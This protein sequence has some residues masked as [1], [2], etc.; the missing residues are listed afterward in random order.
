M[1][2]ILPGGSCLISSK[3]Y[4]DAP[5]VPAPVPCPY[6]GA[7]RYYLGMKLAGRIFWFPQPDDCDCPGAAA[8]RQQEQ[9]EKEAQAKEEERRQREKQRDKLI[10]RSGLSKRFLRRTFATFQVTPENQAAYRACRRYVQDFAGLGPEQNSLMLA[11]GCGTGKTHLAAAIANGLLEQLVEVAFTTPNDL[12]AA[13]R[14]TFG[15]DRGEEEQVVG[16]Y[17]RAPLLVLDDLGKDQPTQWSV[18]LLYRILNARYEN[19]APVVVTTNYDAAGLVKRL[20]PPGGDGIT[21][22]A[23]VDRLTEVCRYLPLTGKSHR[24]PGG[25]K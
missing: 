6:C 11:G 23:I 4:P 20:T 25:E 14:A 15:K 8:Q 13:V 5:N 21:G 2:R 3:D 12:T 1:E 19:D 22:R 9:A 17:Q 10:G 7:N 24:K 18:A 16:F